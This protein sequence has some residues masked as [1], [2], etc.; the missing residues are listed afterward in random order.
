MEKRD[1]NQGNQ[2]KSMFM[3]KNKNKSEIQTNSSMF[4]TKGKDNVKNQY[5]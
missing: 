2:Q 1:N 5:R 4:N 3:S